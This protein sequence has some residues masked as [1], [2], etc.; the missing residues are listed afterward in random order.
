MGVIFLFFLSWKK[1]RKNNPPLIFCILYIIFGHN[2]NK[3]FLLSLLAFSI[4]K[5]IKH[6]KGVLTMTSAEFKKVIEEREAR[7]AEWKTRRLET[8]AKEM[9]DLVIDEKKARLE[10]DLSL[11][12]QLDLSRYIKVEYWGALELKTDYGFH[13]DFLNKWGEEFVVIEKEYS[14][15]VISDWDSC[16]GAGYEEFSKGTGKRYKGKRRRR[17]V[18]ESSKGKYIELNGKRHYINDYKN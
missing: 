14:V 2:F 3:Y 13:I 18:N 12:Y 5:I 7:Q 1:L 4:L 10:S 8:L 17:V 6:S 9:P 16:I 11:T 15:V